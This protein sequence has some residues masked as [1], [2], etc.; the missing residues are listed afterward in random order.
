MQVFERSWDTITHHC[1]LQILLELRQQTLR[2][3]T[4]LYFLSKGDFAHHF[5]AVNCVLMKM[6]IFFFIYI[7]QFLKIRAVEFAIIH[8]KPEG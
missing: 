1:L 8:L 6:E 2:N 5:V 7:L 4:A 3:G